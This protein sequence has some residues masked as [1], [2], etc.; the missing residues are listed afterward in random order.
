[1]EKEIKPAH[2]VVIS[3]IYWQLGPELFQNDKT[4][5]VVGC[6]VLESRPSFA[7]RYRL[8]V[9]NIPAEWKIGNNCVSFY[10]LSFKTTLWEAIFI[11]TLLE[12]VSPGWL[13]DWLW[14]GFIRL[15]HI[16]LWSTHLEGLF[17]SL[18]LFHPHFTSSYLALLF[19]LTRLTPGAPLNHSGWEPSQSDTMMLN[20]S[21]MNTWSS[22]RL[23]V[24]GLWWGVSVQGGH[25]VFLKIAVCYPLTLSL[26]WLPHFGIGAPI[27]LHPKQRKAHAL[28][29][30]CCVNIQ[31]R[32]CRAPGLPAEV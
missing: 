13:T 24:L 32:K 28:R 7:L 14:W 18:S 16:P 27:I 19:C 29:D 2:V 21:P 5:E 9:A 3:K 26:I 30:I 22:G 17:L 1:M 11:R 10:L 4:K 6:L 20:S 31:F 23:S 8:W 25:A 15:L 12:H